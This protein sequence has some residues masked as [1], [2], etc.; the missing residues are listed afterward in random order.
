MATDYVP[1]IG[2]IFG[3]S[4]EQI[5]SALSLLR[6]RGRVAAYHVY[7]FALADAR[8]PEVN[9]RLAYNARLRELGLGRI[10]DDC[11]LSQKEVGD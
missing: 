5:T 7:R 4:L 11:V 6:V 1:Q 2:V 9:R 8:V 3:R 10:R